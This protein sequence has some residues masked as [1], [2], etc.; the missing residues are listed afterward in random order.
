MVPI[1]DSPLYDESPGSHPAGQGPSTGAHRLRRAYA[2]TSRAHAGSPRFRSLTAGLLRIS[3]SS[4]ASFSMAR[5]GITRF[6][7]VSRLKRVVHK[8]EAARIV[9]GKSVEFLFYRTK[10]WDA[11]P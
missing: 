9:G 11:N 1:L 2:H 10:G 4:R 6:F 3:P 8:S 5:T 7:N